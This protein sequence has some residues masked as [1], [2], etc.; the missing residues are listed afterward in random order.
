ML[1]L[2]DNV[3]VKESLFGHF[4]Q[5]FLNLSFI[6]KN[7]LVGLNF[8]FVT[9]YLDFELFDPSLSPIYICLQSLLVSPLELW[10]SSLY[11]E[12]SLYNLA[13]G[14]VLLV[15]RR[16]WTHDYG[17]ILLLSSYTLEFLV[18]PLTVEHLASAG[19]LFDGGSH[20][21]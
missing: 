6:L 8:L 11:L 12:P 10:P 21:G 9:T 20:I 4:N 15:P 16:Y 14:H 5:L 3:K 19:K 13:N 7:S 18:Y 1:L 2:N 17:I